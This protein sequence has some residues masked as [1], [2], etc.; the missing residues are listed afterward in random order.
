MSPKA[1]EADHLNC[2]NAIKRIRRARDKA[3]KQKT[4]FSKLAMDRWSESREREWQKEGDHQRK[5][6]QKM[7]V[8]RYQWLKKSTESFQ[9]RKD[10]LGSSYVIRN[11]PSKC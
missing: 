1:F 10:H 7:N 5:E 4:I 3:G 6:R 11:S 9:Q 2:P 8:G